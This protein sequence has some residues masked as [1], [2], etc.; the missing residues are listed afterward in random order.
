MQALIKTLRLH[1]ASD[2][3]SEESAPE[4]SDDER[5]SSDESEGDMKKGRDAG[6][7]EG[8]R[9]GEQSSEDESTPTTSFFLPS[10]THI[11]IG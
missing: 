8:G 7:S 10:S 4:D 2:D 5:G 9:E 11:N 1:P 3:E 6:D